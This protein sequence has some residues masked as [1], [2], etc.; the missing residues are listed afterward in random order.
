MRNPN[1][2]TDPQ[3]LFQNW[4]VFYDW[5]FSGE[6]PPVPA[7]EIIEDDK[8]LDSYIASWKADIKKKKQGDKKGYD[9]SGNFYGSTKRRQ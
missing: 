1:E 4:L 8:E 5:I 3:I 6:G 2:L 9:N 7:K